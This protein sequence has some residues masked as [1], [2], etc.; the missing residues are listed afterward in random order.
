MTSGEIRFSY[1]PC[2]TAF[3]QCASLLF[4]WRNNMLPLR[5]PLGMQQPQQMLERLIHYRKKSRSHRSRDDQIVAIHWMNHPWFIRH[6]CQMVFKYIHHRRSL[7]SVQYS[8]T[9]D[10]ENWT[11]SP[12]SSFSLPSLALTR[13]SYSTASCYWDTVLFVFILLCNSANITDTRV[14]SLPGV[15]ATTRFAASSLMV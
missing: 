15:S 10:S 9:Y 5:Q 6:L 4:Q 13:D 12:I 11:N 14:F 1:W 7:F 2:E 3:L 8:W